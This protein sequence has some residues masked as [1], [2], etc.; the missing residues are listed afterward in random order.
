MTENQWDARLCFVDPPWAYFTTQDFAE[1][2]GEGWEEA[3]YQDFAGPP[4][5]PPLGQDRP[6][7]EIVKIAYDCND[8]ITPAIMLRKA[9]LP[10]R[11]S[12]N[13]INRGR[14]PWLYLEPFGDSGVQVAAGCSL[15]SFVAGYMRSMNQKVYAPLAEE[16]IPRLE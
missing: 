10:I 16:A 13:D 7:W 11:L 15:R 2:T 9:S 3:P 4:N 8:L 1:Q 12:V 5:E 14:A 6:A